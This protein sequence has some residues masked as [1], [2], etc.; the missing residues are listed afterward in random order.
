[1]LDKINADTWAL[2][3]GIWSL[4]L[5]FLDRNWSS[6]YKYKANQNHIA[7]NTGILST[8]HFLKPQNLPRKYLSKTKILDKLMESSISRTQSW[9]QGCSLVLLFLRIFSRKELGLPLTLYRARILIHRYAYIHMEL[10]TD[11]SLLSLG[12]LVTYI[13]RGDTGLGFWSTWQ[14]SITFPP[15]QGCVPLKVIKLFH[16]VSACMLYI[17]Y[18]QKIN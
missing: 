2:S 13:L 12:P 3:W 11:N 5:N 9:H 15:K 14:D 8:W 6:H 16:T 1:M 10:H 17:S 18:H 4:R 7:L